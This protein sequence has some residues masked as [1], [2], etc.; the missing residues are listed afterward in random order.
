MRSEPRVEVSWE[1]GRVWG[2]SEREERVSKAGVQGCRFDDLSSPYPLGVS[3]R[4]SEGLLG[5]AGMMVERCRTSEE[6]ERNLKLL[7]V[8]NE[9]RVIQPIP[10]QPLRSAILN[11]SESWVGS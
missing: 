8:V 4:A 1:D 5:G 7:V 10:R 9:L 11:I 2:R 3:R 6:D